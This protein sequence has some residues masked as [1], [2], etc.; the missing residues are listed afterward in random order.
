MELDKLHVLV[1]QSGAGDHGRAVTGGG[2]RAGA[3]EVGT[4]VAASGQHLE[5][6]GGDGSVTETATHMDQGHSVAVGNL[7]EGWPQLMNHWIRYIRIPLNHTHG[8]TP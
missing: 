5:G 1:G 4:A 3:R 6:G 8:F 7:S 2:V